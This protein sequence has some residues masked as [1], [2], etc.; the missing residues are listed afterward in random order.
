[1]KNPLMVG[2]N[3]REFSL[4]FLAFIIPGGNW[5]FANLTQSYWSKLPGNIYESSVHLGIP[6]LFILV[7]TW[8]K[9]RNF[10]ERG[11]WYSMFVFFFIM[12]LGPVLHVWG[13]EISVIKLPYLLFEKL[14]PLLTLSG[15]PVRMVSMIILSASVISAI[16]FKKLFRHSWK[17]RILSGILILILFFEY[18]PA[19]IPT[20]KKPIPEYINVLKNLP[21]KKGVIDTTNNGY[22]NAYYQTIHE[23]PLVF[24]YDYVARVS[25][26]IYQKEQ[27][28]KQTIADKQYSSLWHDYKV[29]YFITDVSIEIFR[30]DLPIKTI[31]QDDKVKLYDLSLF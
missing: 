6:V 10:K 18:L 20:F 1:M 27:K 3:S 24:C 25:K 19:P 11:L 14:F 5:R 29:R 2:H 31:Y 21:D 4:D 13:K 9:G 17:T 15:L 7:Y 28:I 23:K 26:S 12:A 22:L 16:G 30:D 8:I